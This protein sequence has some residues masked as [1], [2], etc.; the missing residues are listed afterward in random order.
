MWNPPSALTPEEQK[1]AARTRK[2]RKFFVFLRARRHELLDA[3]FQAPLAAIYRAA[4]GGKEPVEA[5][6][7]ALA[8]LLQAYCHVGDRDA[9][10]RTVM[11]TRW[12]WVLDGLGAERPPFSQGTLFNFRMRLMAHNLDKILL[13]RPVA[14]AAQTGGCGAR[15]RRAAL[16]STPRLGAGRV[17]DTLHLLG[18]AVGKAVGLAARELGTAA[19][20]ILEEAGWVLVGHSSLKGVCSGY[21]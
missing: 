16:D 4:P 12:Q 17:A 13:E 9:V 14:L 18:H 20:A 7:L 6:R 10:E 1:M 19:E 8:T 2:A 15:Q 21:V 5:G 3:T 11:D